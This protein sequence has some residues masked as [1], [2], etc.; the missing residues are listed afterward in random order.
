MYAYGSSAGGTLAALLSGDHLV[1]AAVA[2]APVSDLLT[3]TWPLERYGP[4]YWESLGVD[5]A[6][7]ERLS[8]IRRPQ[9]APLLVIQVVAT[10]SC[11]HR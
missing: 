3:W 9:L 4:E 10:T 11:R 6:C 8:P 2:K 1:G 7:R 5:Q